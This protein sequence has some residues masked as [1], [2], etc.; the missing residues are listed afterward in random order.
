V[1]SVEAADDAGLT[2]KIVDGKLTISAA[3]K[4]KGRTHDV[5]VKGG[6]MDLKIKL[7]VMKA[8]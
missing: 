1:P 7:K 3:R 6:K 5:K 2:A 8:E 4:A